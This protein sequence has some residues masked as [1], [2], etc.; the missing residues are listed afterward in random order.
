MVVKKSV[1]RGMPLADKRDVRN[2]NY[3]KFKS[4]MGR[5]SKRFSKTAVGVG[6]G[7]AAL[8]PIAGGVMVATTLATVSIKA[9]AAVTDAD[10]KQFAKSM[11]SAANSKNIGQVARLISD[12]ALISVSR[13][14]KTSTLDKTS[15]LSLLQ[16]NWSK[17]S[18][19]R[20]DIAVTNVVMM[21]NQ[22][23]ADVVTTEVLT[24]NGV[25]MRLVTTSRTTFTETANGLVLSRAI[26][27]LTI[28]Q[29]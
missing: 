19:Y 29:H 26:C 28:E 10:L 24:E 13:K 9:Q 7:L 20:Y 4:W 23:K 18:Q 14:G 2:M 1:R 11:N 15:Y 3:A 17:A 22:A 5:M 6:I 8:L 27:Q 21:G 12:D 25:S 16:N